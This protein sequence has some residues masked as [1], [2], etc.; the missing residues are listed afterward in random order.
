MSDTPKTKDKNPY[1][2][3]GAALAKHDAS[4]EVEAP[5]PAKE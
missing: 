2:P 1:D 4:T 5:Q 3:D